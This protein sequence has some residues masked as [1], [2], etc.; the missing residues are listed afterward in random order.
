V[1]VPPRVTTVTVTV[2]LPGGAVTVST[3]H[4]AFTENDGAAVVPKNTAVTSQRSVPWMITVLP[5]PGSPLVGEIPV[6][7]GAGWPGRVPA[8]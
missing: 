6:I 5:P 2:P 3:V 7:T 1:V 8:T 4:E